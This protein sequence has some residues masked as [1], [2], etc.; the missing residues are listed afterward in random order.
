MLQ[1]FGLCFHS[2]CKYGQL[3]TVDACCF[4]DEAPDRCVRIEL[5]PEQQRVKGLQGLSVVCMGRSN[6][7][8]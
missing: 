1:R 5:P 7:L 6:F 8:M 4:H 2:M 3:E